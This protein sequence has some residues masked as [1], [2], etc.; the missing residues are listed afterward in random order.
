MTNKTTVSTPEGLSLL[1]EHIGVSLEDLQKASETKYEAA[2][3]ERL[4]QQIEAEREAE[5]RKLE[6]SLKALHEAWQAGHIIVRVDGKILPKPGPICKTG[7]PDLTKVINLTIGARGRLLQQFKS[8]NSSDEIQKG[9][10]I[11]RSV[12]CTCEKDHFVEVFVSG[13]TTK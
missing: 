10:T 9:A 2:R 12:P 8:M 6:R 7:E 3:I 1:A 11:R 13:Y 5:A 4:S